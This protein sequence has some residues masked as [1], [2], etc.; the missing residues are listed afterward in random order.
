M[1]LHKHF[2]K[3]AIENQS[4]AGLQLVRGGIQKSACALDHEANSKSTRA[5]DILDQQAVPSRYAWE[6]SQ[7]SKH[8]TIIS[9]DLLPVRHFNAFVAKHG[10]L[11]M[12]G[13]EMGQH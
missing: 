1:L 12:T 4:C 2:L 3:H 9:V 7:V 13:E 10:T 5:W 8:R 11:G 6:L